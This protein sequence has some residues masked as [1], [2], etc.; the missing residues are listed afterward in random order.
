[1]ECVNKYRPLTKL[2]ITCSHSLQVGWR[3]R[4]QQ[5]QRRNDNWDI[6]GDVRSPASRHGGHA[7]RRTGGDAHDAGEHVE[8]TTGRQQAGAGDRRVA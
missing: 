2:K 6:A 8:R 5:C 4:Q 7:H 1:M 3:Q